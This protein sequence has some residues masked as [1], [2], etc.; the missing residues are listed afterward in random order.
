LLDSVLL[1]RLR[2]QAL[3]FALNMALIRAY[4]AAVVG[5]SLSDLKEVQ[6]AID[7][8]SHFVD[9]VRNINQLWLW[10]W[11]LKF[12]PHGHLG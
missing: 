1:A 7:Q 5:V 9:S 6:L 11:R 2:C 3:H 4:L 8:K 10:C 12:L